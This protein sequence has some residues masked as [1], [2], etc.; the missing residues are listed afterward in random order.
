[1]SE[2]EAGKVESEKAQIITSMI[3][4]HNIESTAAAAVKQYRHQPLPPQK[5][6]VETMVMVVVI[7]SSRVNPFDSMFRFNVL[8][9]SNGLSLWK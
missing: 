9:S 4:N 3:G 5:A 7:M 2:A 1:M 8:H 6:A